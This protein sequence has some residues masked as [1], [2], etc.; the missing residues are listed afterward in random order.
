M[1][2]EGAR[3][4]WLKVSGII[5]KDQISILSNHGRMPTIAYN[6]SSKRFD[7]IFWPL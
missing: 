4:Q 5:M 7:I 1:K 6:S 3:D 2:N